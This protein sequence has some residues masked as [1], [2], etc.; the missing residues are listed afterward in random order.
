[1][2]LSNLPSNL[3]VPED[4]GAANHLTGLSLPNI[5]L[6]ATNGE[7][8]NL[9]NFKGY[10]VIYI[11]PMTGRPDVALPDNW[12][13]IPGAR[14]CTPQSCSFRDHYQELQDLNAQV[15]GLSTQD[16]DY[17]NEA[18]SRLD[19]P[20]ELLSD[21]SLALKSS[22]SLPTMTVEG[23]ELYKRLTLI[24]FDAEIKK[25]F[26]P[27]FPPDKNVDDVILWLKNN[28]V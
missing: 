24:T 13:A 1:M 9:A 16:S 4:D 25:V 10:C 11:Y 21:T 27:V 28:Q 7:G 15:F 17:Q 18:K 3:P 12:E 20:Y 23:M 14:G 19:L 2:A 22:L 8:I 6:T 26:Y 5:T